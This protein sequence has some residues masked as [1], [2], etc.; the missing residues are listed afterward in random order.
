M[1][2]CLTANEILLC[3]LFRIHKPNSFDLWLVAITRIYCIVFV[4][5][6]YDDQL[7]LFDYTQ[8]ELLATTLF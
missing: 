8:H 2:V 3:G 6:L 5:E 1:V 4:F 7:D